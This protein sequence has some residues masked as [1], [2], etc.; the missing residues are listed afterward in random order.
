ML[1]DI[2]QVLNG[3]IWRLASSQIVF[4][5]K[6]Q[7]IVGLILLYSCRQFERQMGSRKFGAFLAFSC[8]TSLLALLALI[9]V[10]ASIGYNLI[11]SPGPFFLIYSLVAFYYCK[12]SYCMRLLP[13]LCD[14]ICCH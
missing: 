4:R 13:E 11:P 6:A 12:P 7:A 14:F 9:V 8:A 2:Q 1:S 10:A 5:N 3:E